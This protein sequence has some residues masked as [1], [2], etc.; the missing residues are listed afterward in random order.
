MN[1][2]KCMII[3]KLRDFYICM[4]W[5]ILLFYDFVNKCIINLIYIYNV[6]NIY[7]NFVVLEVNLFVFL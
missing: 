7:Y 3:I 4:Y 6:L 1:F 5:I 2:L